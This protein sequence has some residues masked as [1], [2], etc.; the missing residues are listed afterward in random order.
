MTRLSIRL[1]MVV[2]LTAGAGFADVPK[3]AADS[4]PSIFGAVRSGH[5]DGVESLLVEEGAISARREDG[6]TLLM[7]A[8]VH[9]DIAMVRLLLDRGADVTAEDRNGARALTWALHDRKKVQALVDGGAKVEFRMGEDRSGFTPLLLV[10]GYPGGADTVR[11][12]AERGANVNADRRGFTVLANASLRGD[13]ATV[14]FL[15]ERGAR[16]EARGNYQALHGAATKGPPARVRF[17][18]ENGA[19]ADVLV[20]GLSPVAHAAVHGNS[21]SVRQLIEAGADANSR[22]QRFGI[23]PLLW[24]AGM[25]NPEVVR[26]LLDAGV[27]V[28]AVD[29]SGNNALYWALRRGDEKT[30]RMLRKAGVKEPPGQVVTPMTLLVHEKTEVKEITARSIRRSVTTSLPLIQSSSEAFSESRSCFSCHHQSLAAM[31]VAQARTRGLQVSEGI[32]KA[33]LEVTRKAFESTRELLMNGLGATDDPAPAYALVG[34]LAEKQK[35]D[36]LTDALVQYLVVRQEPEGYW[37]TLGVRPP[38]DY[39]DFTYTALAV[40]GLEHYSPPGRR[41]ELRTILQRAREWLTRSEPRDT[42]DRAFQLLG[43]GWSQ[44]G[45]EVVAKRTRELLADQ[46]EDGG[47]AQL[48]TLG[49]DAYATGLALYA[50][51]V[52]G[53]VLTRHEAYRK[54]LRYLIT[55]QLADGSWYVKKRAFP[56]QR[57][58]DADFPHGRDQFISMAA[59]CWATMGLLLSMDRA[60]D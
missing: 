47:W 4:P 49:S 25:G 26:A 58:F 20:L 24:S 43:L 3:S 32:A 37:D 48:D 6:S 16:T 60:P 36:R 59:T 11:F 1:S 55:T 17:L 42:E 22:S 56:L 2:V 30:A 50:L 51:H 31:A 12:L 15:L 34:F 27:D 54:G 10:A 18:L 21:A 29:R 5:L 28:D 41:S 23:T 14:R 53:G 7:E 8:V 40:R 44:A 39:S 45:Q 19:K 9:A 13:F 57:H 38:H 33:Q 46:R 35:P 52:G